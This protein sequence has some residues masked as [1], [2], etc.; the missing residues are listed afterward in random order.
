MRRQLVPAIISMVIFTVLLGLAYPLLVTG[1]AQAGFKDKADGSLIKE[2]GKVVGSSMLAQ[3]FTNAKGNPIRKYF[4][5]RPSAANYD[6]TYSTGSNYGPLNPKLI[7]RCL[8][9]QKTDKAGNPVVD[10]KGNPVYETN[11]DG[12]K[13]CDPN[14]VPQ[15]A[16]SYRKLNGL[17]NSVK[18]P[19]DAVTASGSG[20]DPDISIANARLQAARVAKA[21]GL[22]VR[23]VLDMVD[24][25]TDGRPLGIIGEKTVNVLDLNLALDNLRS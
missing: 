10:K 21:R 18:V 25:H 7:A 2:N 13:V 20:L 15:R 9:V 8:P 1:I 14:T 6:P 12:S 22:S 23:K 5:E 4:Q 16:V 17:A 24:A 3:P 19:V 11:P